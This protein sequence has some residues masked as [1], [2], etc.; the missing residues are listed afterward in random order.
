MK[1]ADEMT[2]KE[3]IIKLETRIDNQEQ[4]ICK[5]LEDIR[6]IKDKLLGRPSWTVSIIITFLFT[7]CASL[8]IINLK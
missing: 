6:E 5:I 2:D 4:H 1:N 3:R 7:L 8:I